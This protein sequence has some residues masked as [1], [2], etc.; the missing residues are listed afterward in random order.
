MAEKKQPSFKKERQ[1]RIFL[2]ILMMLLLAVGLISLAYPFVSDSLNNLLDQRLINYYQEQANQENQAAIEKAQAEMSASNQEL[3]ETGSQIGADPWSEGDSQTPTIVDSNYFQEHTIAVL[4]I[5]SLNLEL[6]LFDTTND[7]LLE[8]GTTLVNGTSFP[9]GGPSTHAVIA[10]HRGLPEAELF[11]NLPELAIG[12]VFYIEING[13]THAYEVDQTKVVEPTETADLQIVEGED[14]VTLLTCTPYMI[15]DHRLLVR[16]HRVAYVPERD[17]QAVANGSTQRW[18]KIAVVP[19]GAILVALL[20]VYLFYKWLRN[21]IVSGHKYR[22][23]F[24]LLTGDEKPIGNARFELYTKN[25]KHPI[26]RE[27]VAI[28]AQ[29]DETG[30][31]LIED[32]KGGTYLLKGADGNQPLI[33][34][35]KKV[36]GTDFTLFSKKRFYFIKNDVEP[37][38]IKLNSK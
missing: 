26:T 4:K 13:E 17:D 23:H 27:E 31:F 11:T 30:T 22:L 28:S 21:L 37:V 3:A 18:L 34:K 29:T 15:N 20:A 12:D 33:A 16:G 25:G 14:L 5:P 1:K 38:I 36:R 19:G 2:D 32:V 10:G 7:L 35:I 6:P 9:I 8:K 24:V